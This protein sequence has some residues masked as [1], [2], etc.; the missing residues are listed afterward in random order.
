[1]KRHLLWIGLTL[2]LASVAL[3]P[4]PAQKANPFVGRWDVTVTADGVKYPSWIEVTE[5]G[6]AL[7]ARVQQRTGN[8]AP[9]A[10]VKM[11]GAR[12]IVTVLEA[13]PARPA[14]GQRP[15]FAGRP[16]LVWELSESGGKLT[17]AQ[18]HGSTV[19][20]LAGVRAP[21]LKRAAPKAWSDPEPLFNGKDLTGWTAVNNTPEAYDQ[22]FTSHWTVRNG[23]LTNE[24]RGSNLRTTRVFNDFKIHAEYICPPE[25]NSGIYLRGRYEAQVGPPP[26][27]A[28]RAGAAGGRK[29]G[30]PPAAAR[31]AGYRNPYGFVGCIYGML[32]PS[33]PPPFRPEW[34]TYDITLVGRWVTVAFNGVTTI[35]NQEIAGPTGGA[36]DAN[37]GEPGPIYI[38]GDHHGGIRYRSL[39]ISVPKR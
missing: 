33:S 37:E 4:A 19:W 15:A 38:Q 1:M 8:V 13:A 6:G 18:K 22:K 30:A 14:E 20:R 9:V 5:N 10:G 39:T 17:G 27:E 3:L 21:A 12:L 7:D 16:E 28:E 35:D 24:A 25:E 23:E 31:G 26:S 36:L 34:Q 11:E 29:G 32:G 2:A